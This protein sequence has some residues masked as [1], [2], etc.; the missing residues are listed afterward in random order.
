VIGK[1]FAG[2]LLSELPGGKRRQAD[3]Q[4]HRV[5]PFP[6]GLS[7]LMSDLAPMPFSINESSERRSMRRTPRAQPGRRTNELITSSS[8]TR[9]SSRRGDSPEYLEAIG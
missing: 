9:S 8:F 6:F 5:R 1:Y 7:A 2:A 4:G 3:G